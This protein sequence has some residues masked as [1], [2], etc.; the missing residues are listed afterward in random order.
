MAPSLPKSR[1]E[2]HVAIPV[3]R[4]AAAR[5]NGPK[6]RRAWRVERCELRRATGSC[7]VARRPPSSTPDECQCTYRVDTPRRQDPQLTSAASDASMS[8]CRGAQ[9][10]LHERSSL[11]PSLL[12][13]MPQLVD[14]NFTRSVVLLWEH[15]DEG[16]MGLIINR[17][18]ETLASQI[19]QLDPPV[20][21]ESDLTVWIGG[22]VDPTRGWLLIAGGE[23]DGSEII[24]GLYLSA[25]V[26]RL[27]QAMESERKRGTMPF[28]GGICGLG[29][30][31]A[32]HG[33]RGVGMADGSARHRSRL[34]HAK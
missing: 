26:G 10:M 28:P 24:P 33:A 34:P 27:R 8:P 30:T 23:R 3:G 31:T 9:R 29:R 7:P 22:P 21:N 17:P 12:V 2:C 14:P 25:S 1:G 15:R 20:E 4:P 16:A 5:S 11:A 19:V 18:T 32:R 13:A 6:H